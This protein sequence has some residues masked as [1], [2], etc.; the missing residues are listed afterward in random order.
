MLNQAHSSRSIQPYHGDDRGD[1]RQ[2]FTQAPAFH[3]ESVNPFIRQPP[4][5]ENILAVL[6]HVDHQEARGRMQATIDIVDGQLREGFGQGPPHQCHSRASSG[7]AIHNR[8]QRKHRRQAEHLGVGSQFPHDSTASPP[9]QNMMGDLN[10]L[11]QQPHAPEYAMLVTDAGIPYQ[12]TQERIDQDL[13]GFGTQF[14]WYVRRTHLLSELEASHK[15]K[16]DSMCCGSVRVSTRQYPHA[17]R[18][19]SKR[20]SDGC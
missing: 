20:R 12:Q 10:Y 9:Q 6:P 14:A 8:R 15:P 5:D 19:G 11:S 3:H 18:R 4:V 7:V 16:Q 13:R 1:Q 2:A 17:L